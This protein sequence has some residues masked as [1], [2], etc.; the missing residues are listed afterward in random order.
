M[1]TQLFVLSPIL[2]MAIWK[3]KKYAYHILAGLI[4]VAIVIPL[5][6]AYRKQQ[7]IEGYVIMLMNFVSFK[8]KEDSLGRVISSSRL[9]HLFQR[10]ERTP[11]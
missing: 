10:F 9:M 11:W 6:I 1:D 3:W 4:A 2:L 7:L 8:A 5:Q